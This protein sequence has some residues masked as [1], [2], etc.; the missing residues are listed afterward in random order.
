M[1]NELRLHTRAHLKFFLRNRLVLGV[2]IAAGAFWALGFIPFLM[3][4]SDGG[5]FERLKH[6]TKQIHGLAW[7]CGGLLALIAMSSQLRD[8]STRLVFTRPVRPELWVASVIVSAV[9]V[10]VAAHAVTALLTLGLSVAWGVP[11]QIGFLWLSIDGVLQTLVLVSLLATLGAA[12]HPVLAG[13]AMAFFNEQTF[14]YLYSMLGGAKQ[15][16][17]SSVWLAIGHWVTRTVYTVVPMLDPFS[18]ETGAVNASLR[19]RSL[20]WGY[21]LA[22]AAYAALVTSFCFFGA[23]L[24]L[25]RRSH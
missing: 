11:Y 21:L 4:E 12:I 19:V 14:Y 7:F 25:R 18:N 9:L 13:F 1:L 5:R 6:L 16:G 15:A 2:V 10:S 20:D 8:R 23:T 22:T 17:S 3:F 24:A